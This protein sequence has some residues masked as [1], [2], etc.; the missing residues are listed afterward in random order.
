MLYISLYVLDIVDGKDSFSYPLV[1]T[2]SLR[3]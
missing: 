2:Y 3:F 1:N